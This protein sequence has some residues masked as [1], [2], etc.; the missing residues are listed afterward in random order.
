MA[1]A[2]VL[3]LWARHDS[4]SLWLDELLSA[5]HAGSPDLPAL[6]RAILGDVHPPLHPLL[7]FG[8]GRLFGL[9]GET[10]RLGNV[11]AVA[12]H[13]AIATL[14]VARQWRAL[15]FAGAFLMPQLWWYLFELRPYL[16]AMLGTYWLAAWW[17]AGEGWLVA[18]PRRRAAAAV[19]ISL[20]AST[21]YFGIASG[22]TVLA[23]LCLRDRTRFHAIWFALF[24]LATA[25]WTLWHLRTIGALLGGAFSTSPFGWS[26]VA[27]WLHLASGGVHRPAF[28]I[29]ALVAA[30]V[31]AGRVRPVAAIAVE[32]AP[33]LVSLAGLCLISLHTP[34]AGGRNLLVLTPFFVVPALA[35]L[36]LSPRALAL[37]PAIALLVLGL[38][39]IKDYAY[40]E[41]RAARR[42]EDQDWR[43]AAALAGQLATRLELGRVVVCPYVPAIYAHYFR[44][45]A[46]L[47]LCEG[48]NRLT[49]AGLR[50]AT[51]LWTS[52][53]RVVSIDADARVVLAR[54]WLALD[55]VGHRIHVR[56]SA[57]PPPTGR[58]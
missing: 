22:W 55:L 33:G 5:M 51:L 53:D 16:F 31:V 34:M 32:L 21:H 56:R 37:A 54:D 24:A 23:L 46:R 27:Y 50:D 40:T 36:A 11:L 3:L 18:D 30:W 41:G 39:N 7:L 25:A 58:M 57:L 35:R 52:D 14:L 48:G 13:L 20:L 9:D 19:L 17:V 4:G 44:A 2:A 10:G 8:F 45:A 1:A 12:V 49:E 29:A 15:A 38:L 6:T 28:L 26:H 47:V 43:A 42:L